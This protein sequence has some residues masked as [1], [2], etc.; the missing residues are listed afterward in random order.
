[1][2]ILSQ[3]LDYPIEPKFKRRHL[4]A[5]VKLSELSRRYPECLTLKHIKL[6]E[7]HVAR[8]S[9]GDIYKGSMAGC[10][11]AVKVLNVYQKSDMDTVLKVRPYS[12]KLPQLLFRGVPQNFAREAVI[13][14]QLA[15]PNVLPFFGVFRLGTMRDRLCLACPW[16]ENGN[17]ANYLS[18]VAPETNCVQLVCTLVS[19]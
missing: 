4:K 12:S 18:A 1:M 5:L 8:G 15:H 19:Y 9:F 11:I 6:P 3:R 17:L 16:M 14:R 13:W 7:Y 2:T 10:D